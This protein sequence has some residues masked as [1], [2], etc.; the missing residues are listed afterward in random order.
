MLDTSHKESA[1]K[2]HFGS[3]RKFFV[4]ACLTLA[5][6]GCKEILYSDI[7]ERDINMMVMLLEKN[8]IS[9]RRQ[10][11]DEK[12][13]SLLV[14]GSNFTEAV[15]VLSAEGYPKK[16]FK[17]FGDIFSSD[18]I[19]KTPFE[20]RARFIHALN[21]ELSKS[22]SEIDG[23]VSARV[24]VMIPEKTRF[25]TKT[26]KAT[27]AVMILHNQGADMYSLQPKIKQFVAHSVSGV[28]YENVSIVI[29]PSGQSQ[30]NAQ[31]GPTSEIKDMNLAGTQRFNG[32]EYGQV[33]SGAKLPISYADYNNASA[34]LGSRSST[35][36]LQFIA[37]IFLGAAGACIIIA[38]YMRPKRS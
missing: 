19:V 31:S 25:G 6:S 21:E 33:S 38:L 18:T 29:M 9:A 10:K 11:D 5:L 30:Q 14:D 7:P 12:N 34:K 23:V 32:Q 24:H 1:S 3:L 26:D 35:S 36:I 17:T 28:S 37:L 16:K 27:A 2:L 15:K 13:F 4:F 20:Q 8:G 22:L